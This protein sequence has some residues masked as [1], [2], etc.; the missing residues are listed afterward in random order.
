MKYFALFRHL[1]SFS[2]VKMG[3]SIP[4]KFD[5]QKIWSDRGGN[6]EDNCP[7]TIDGRPNE[8][9]INAISA[10]ERQLTQFDLLLPTGT[11]LDV[12]VG[13]GVM[14]SS[15]KK[16]FPVSVSV[17]CDYSYPSLY[18]CSEK[19][20]FPVL[21]CTAEQLPLSSSSIDF[22]LFY[23]VSHYL[24]NH[25]SFLEIIAEFERVLKPGGKILIGDV[26]S[27]EVLSY[28]HFN[29]RWFYP[30]AKK[31]KR[32]IRKLGLSI[33]IVPQPEYAPYC[34][35]RVDWILKKGVDKIAVTT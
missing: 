19:H 32:D 5:W 1:I 31:V 12:G 7:E 23:S 34:D 15:L 10:V 22:I 27:Y 18:Y 25:K 30:N 14:H 17:G 11:W 2:L 21:N 24:K 29:P 28:K 6:V 20:G 4:R 9:E 3:Y 8:D 33:K 26:L 13:S 16:K 35:Q